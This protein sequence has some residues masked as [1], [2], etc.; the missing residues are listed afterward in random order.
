M[1]LGIS[2]LQ[3][4]SINSMLIVDLSICPGNVGSNTYSTALMIGEKAA[5]IVA[6]ELDMK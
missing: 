2:R 6:Q 5:G 4:S 3:V 1:G